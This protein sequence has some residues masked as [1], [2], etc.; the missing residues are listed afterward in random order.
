MHKHSYRTYD[1]NT[2]LPNLSIC[3]IVQRLLTLV[4]LFACAII[5]GTFGH[6][7]THICNTVVFCRILIRPQLC[8]TVS[9]DI[10]ILSYLT[11][12]MKHW[13]CRRSSI[14][15]LYVICLL[16]IRL[17]DVIVIIRWTS[18][19][20]FVWI[21]STETFAVWWDRHIKFCLHEHCLT[22]FFIFIGKTIFTKR[23]SCYVVWL[24]AI[25]A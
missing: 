8:A 16:V 14:C 2:I 24:V 12:W 3:K 6:V 5:K 13:P 19:N 25:W 11:V 15:F 23:W 17:F 22:T 4:C 21:W 20:A 10:Y 18:T 7:D 1:S 9:T